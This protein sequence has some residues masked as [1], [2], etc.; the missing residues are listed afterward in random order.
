MLYEQD[1]IGDVCVLR[2]AEPRL[3]STIAPEFKTELLRL[4]EQEGHRKILVDLKTVE[5]ADSSGLGALLFGLRQSRN[6]DGI[7]K[8]VNLNPRVLSLIRIAK[9]DSVLEAFD[10]EQEAVESFAEEEE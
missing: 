3:D 2:V 10:D 1:Q 7:L 8:L 9:L 6:F 4:V 5:Y